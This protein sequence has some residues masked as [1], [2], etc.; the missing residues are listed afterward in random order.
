MDMGEEEA[1]EALDSRRARAMAMTP[2]TSG[3]GL[4]IGPLDKPIALKTTSDVRYVDIVDT[5]ALL[6]KYRDDA[7]VDPTLLVAVDFAL[8]D[9]EG[10]IRTL[11]EATAGDGPFD[12]VVAS[13]VIEHVP[14]LIAWFDELAQVAVDGGHLVLMVPDRRFTFDALRP[15]TTIG[16]IL[17]A[18]TARDLVPSERA[19]Y[20]HFRSYVDASAKELW[21]GRPASDCPRAFSIDQASQ[22]RMRLLETGEYIDS[23]VWMFTPAEFVEQVVELGLLQLCDFVVE[24]IEPTLVDDLEFL[25]LLRRIPRETTVDQRRQEQA[26]GVQSLVDDPVRDAS[27]DRS[28]PDVHAGPDALADSPP[29]MDSGVQ[30]LL[31]SETERKLIGLKRRI[32][33]GARRILG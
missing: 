29:P 10:R 18:H 23:H 1:M 4:E 22:L 25:V 8:Q 21:S 11:P 30:S 3:V 12:W 2:M 6:E 32:V 19:V 7:N 5:P 27:G 13:H 26:S 17:Q 28:G 14:D 20:D 15:R 9:S 33:E 16:Q 31:V 24:R